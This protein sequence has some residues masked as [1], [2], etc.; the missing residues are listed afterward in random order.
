MKTLARTKKKL[1]PSKFELWLE[2]FVL[3]N[4][5]FKFILKP[6]VWFAV[7]LAGAGLQLYY[8]FISKDAPAANYHAAALTSDEVWQI[9]NYTCTSIERMDKFFQSDSEDPEVMLTMARQQYAIIKTV[10]APWNTF[11][12]KLSGSKDWHENAAAAWQRMI[13]FIPLYQHSN[14]PWFVKAYPKYANQGD[15][16][17][18]MA[19]VMEQR[20]PDRLS[21]WMIS[22]KHCLYTVDEPAATAIDVNKSSDDSQYCVIYGEFNNLSY[23]EPTKASIWAQQQLAAVEA[24]GKLSL[25]W[26]QLESSLSAYL[27]LAGDSSLPFETASEWKAANAAAP[28]A[29]LRNHIDSLCS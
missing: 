24:R 11:S 26:T 5:V 17:T 27:A 23:D 4:W 19:V 3:P 18:Y 29:I 25:N 14:E 2:S 1:Y 28:V 6:L 8:P 12:T 13:T 16:K 20:D 9:D 15:F 22:L 7:F 10:I 21:D